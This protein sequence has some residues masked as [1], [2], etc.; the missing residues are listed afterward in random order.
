MRNFLS[1]WMCKN[2]NKSIEENKI[3]AFFPHPL[4]I[5]VLVCVSWLWF[6]AFMCLC[7]EVLIITDETLLFYIF[8]SVFMMK[9]HFWKKKCCKSIKTPRFQPV[10]LGIQKHGYIPHVLLVLWYLV[11]TMSILS[12]LRANLDNLKDAFQNYCAIT[13]SNRYVTVTQCL[14]TKE[15]WYKY[16]LILYLSIWN[17]TW[18]L[19]FFQWWD[20]CIWCIWF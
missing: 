10:S 4:W 19:L 3:L 18:Y 17:W 9:G 20:C 5:C 2:Q 13:F 16:N 1:A 15:K 12:R 14:I 8:F 11:L 6:Y 7:I